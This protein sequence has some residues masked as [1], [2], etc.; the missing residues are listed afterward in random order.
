MNKW[1]KIKS[2]LSMGSP[3]IT[4]IETICHSFCNNFIASFLLLFT[5]KHSNRATLNVA[6]YTWN[7]KNKTKQNRTLVHTADI[8]TGTVCGLS[9]RNSEFH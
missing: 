3:T 7:L 1:V 2:I 4:Q 5:H 6:N 9:Y 8:H